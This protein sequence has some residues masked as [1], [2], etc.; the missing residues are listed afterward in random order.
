MDL[1]QRLAEGLA[2]SASRRSGLKALAAAAFAQTA[3]FAAYGRSADAAQCAVRL[4][5][6]TVCNAPFYTYCN[7]TS[8]VPETCNG[9]QCS[10]PCELDAQYYPQE[11]QSACWCTALE[12]MNKK[13]QIYAYWM[14]CD[15][16]CSI[17][18]PVSAAGQ[19]LGYD[20]TQ[21]P[22]GRYGCGCRERVETQFKPIKKKGR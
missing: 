21:Y 17:E 4:T 8:G 15:C 22:D 19:A 18:I 1:T 5:V 16:A 3:A 14:C 6:D 9:S 20:S 10:G 12:E 2:R 7:E 11:I 13:K